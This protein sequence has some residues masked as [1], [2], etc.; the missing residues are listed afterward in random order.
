MEIRIKTLI[1]IILILLL[2]NVLCTGLGLA[3]TTSEDLSNAVYQNPSY[4]QELTPKTNCDLNGSWS[5]EYSYY[6]LSDLT[7]S[8]TNLPSYV[9]NTAYTGVVQ[10]SSSVSISTPENASGNNGRN[11]YY[12]SSS[13]DGE[14]L[15]ITVDLENL[16]NFIS[17][18]PL[19]LYFDPFVIKNPE[20]QIKLKLSYANSTLGNIIYIQNT[21]FNGGCYLNLLVKSPD[22][23]S[24]GKLTIEL[25]PAADSRA[26]IS[27]I[28]WSEPREESNLQITYTGANK[29]SAQTWYQNLR[30]DS[31]VVIWSPKSNED[32]SDN[33]LVKIG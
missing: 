25:N 17:W 31:G 19:N 10:E 22:P 5:T 2:F 13:L 20:E 24:R 29:V 15:A 1:N 33:N 11:K 27:G 3:L 21:K 4:V 9:K 26:A 14:T 28:F 12:L 32:S 23:H 30:T 16:D 8:Q 7:N 18:L 6:W